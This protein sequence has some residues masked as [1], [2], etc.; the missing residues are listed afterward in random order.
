MAEMIDLIDLTLIVCQLNHLS[1]LLLNLVPVAISEILNRLQHWFWHLARRTSQST[2]HDLKVS[3][4]KCFQTQTQKDEAQLLSKDR[5]QGPG[6]SSLWE[7]ESRT[8]TRLMGWIGVS[9]WAWEWM[10]QMG[11][12][13]GDWEEERWWQGVNLGGS[14]EEGDP[15]GSLSLA[16]SQLK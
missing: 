2:M 13:S 3:K 11:V 4:L 1:D 5:W 12:G 15:R 6:E 10:I 14:E 7:G 8:G 16:L 9:L